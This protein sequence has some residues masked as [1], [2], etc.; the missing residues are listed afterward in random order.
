MHY[1]IYGKGFCDLTLRGDFGL[2]KDGS[3]MRFKGVPISLN[4]AARA[5]NKPGKQIEVNIAG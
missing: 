3:A 4:Y 2:F 5:C 1:S